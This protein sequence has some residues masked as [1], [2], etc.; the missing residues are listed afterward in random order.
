[1]VF[2]FLRSRIYVLYP[3]LKFFQA[4]SR[5]T[6]VAVDTYNEGGLQACEKYLCVERDSTSFTNASDPKHA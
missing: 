6:K 4:M 3:I 2:F 5:T 1:M